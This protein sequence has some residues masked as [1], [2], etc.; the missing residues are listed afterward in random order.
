MGPM[1]SNTVDCLLLDDGVL[2]NGECVEI[3][4]ESTVHRQNKMTSESESAGI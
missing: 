1:A 2:K 3:A 4:K